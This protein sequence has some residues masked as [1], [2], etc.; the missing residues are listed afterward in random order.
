M[1]C[2]VYLVGMSA[3]HIKAW[4]GARKKHFPKLVLIING[5]SSSKGEVYLGIFISAFIGEPLPVEYQITFT[6]VE[7][8]TKRLNNKHVQLC[9]GILILIPKPGKLQDAMTSLR[10]IVLFIS[11]TGTHADKL[12]VFFLQEQSAF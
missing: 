4:N 12:D 9:H 3:Y 10:P 8:S 2:F 6:E 1:R 5:N 7:C 11:N